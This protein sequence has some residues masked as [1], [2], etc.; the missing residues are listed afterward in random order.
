[1]ANEFKHARYFR[2]RLGD[3]SLVT[4]S[5][6]AEARTAMA[7]NSAYDTNS[8]T[9]T[10]TLEDSGQTLKIVYEFDSKSDQDGMKAAVDA[11]WSDTIWPAGTAIGDS[12]G[13]VEHFKTEWYGTD[14]TT[15]DSSD[16]IGNIR[17]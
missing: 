9:K 5:T 15:V 17:K 7:L 13:A 10:E 1:M 11:V 14:G 8:P 12:S 3:S 16:N 6:V 4:F 2:K